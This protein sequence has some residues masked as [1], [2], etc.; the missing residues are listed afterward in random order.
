MRLLLS[1]GIK[2][3]FWSVLKSSTLQIQCLFAFVIKK[4]LHLQYSICVS[5]PYLGFF[6]AFAVLERGYINFVPLFLKLISTTFRVIVRRLCSIIVAY[7]NIS[8]MKG[9]M[10]CVKKGIIS[11]LFLSQLL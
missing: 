4:E 5:R 8:T 11:N 1:L 6:F 2:F 10:R 9:V 7:F 3:Q